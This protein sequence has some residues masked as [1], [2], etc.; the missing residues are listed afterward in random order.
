MEEL[1]TVMTSEEWL[2]RRGRR[3]NGRH[4]R[5]RSGVNLVHRIHEVPGGLIRADFEIRDGAYRNVCLSGDLSCYSSHALQALESR[6]EGVLA[7]ELKFALEEFCEENQ[8]QAS[9]ISVEDWMQ[10][11]DI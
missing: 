4:M 6:I 11:L 1:G 9:E 8:P 5:I 7:G 10:A 2:F 3:M